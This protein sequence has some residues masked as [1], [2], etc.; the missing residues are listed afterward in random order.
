MP[1]RGPYRYYTTQTIRP[2]MVIMDSSNQ[3]PL[4]LSRFPLLGRPDIDCDHCGGEGR[5]DGELMHTAT[6]TCLEPCD[7]PP[8]SSGEKLR[9][10]FC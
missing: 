1:I 4:L 10:N 7:Y 6:V 5:G 8:T 2:D 9:L 3:T